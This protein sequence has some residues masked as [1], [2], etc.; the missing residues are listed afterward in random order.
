MPARRRCEYDNATRCCMAR[1]CRTSLPVTAKLCFPESDLNII[2][3]SPPRSLRHCFYP[4]R[5]SEASF[6]NWQ[7]SAE[8]YTGNTE[9]DRNSDGRRRQIDNNIWQISNRNFCKTDGRP[10]LGQ[11]NRRRTGRRRGWSGAVQLGLKLRLRQRQVAPR[12]A[13]AETPARRCRRLQ[14]PSAWDRASCR[15]QNDGR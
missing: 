2:G 4:Q 15:R 7:L 14:S 1:L 13:P 6:F 12:V 11:A 9:A 8:N 10:F 5:L 3:R